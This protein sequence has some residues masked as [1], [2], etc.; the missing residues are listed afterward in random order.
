[1]LRR[2]ERLL[3]K[4]PGL[5]Q[6]SLREPVNHC[7]LVPTL[8]PALL[9]ELSDTD[10]VK[11]SQTTVSSFYLL[12]AHT[13]ERAARDAQSRDM[14]APAVCHY[15]LP[16]ALSAAQT[17][18][19]PSDHFP[20]CYSPEISCLLDPHV[21]SVPSAGDIDLNYFAFPKPRLQPRPGLHLPSLFSPGIYS[22]GSFLSA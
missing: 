5:C 22:T 10:W 13:A 1:M 19:C 9:S 14:N 8:D 18:T 2:N 4:L 15:S 12:N 21:C 3:E 11:G 7:L 20:S 17:C 16:W 6:K